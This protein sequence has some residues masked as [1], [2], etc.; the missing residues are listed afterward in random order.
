MSE[1]INAAIVGLGRWGQLLVS[2]VDDSDVIQF[3]SAVTRTPAK[4][5][6]FCAKRGIKLS[7]QL[8]DVL[9]DNSINALVIAT[10]HSQHFD[11][12]MAAARAGNPKPFR[13]QPPA[14]FVMAPL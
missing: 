6:T 12:L 2:S 8:D 13:A 3:T 9:R 7:D 11:Q 10:P 1:K 14:A 5:E 4:A